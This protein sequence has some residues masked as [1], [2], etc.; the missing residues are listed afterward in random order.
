MSLR[1]VPVFFIMGLLLNECIN[2]AKLP[3]LQK[4]VLESTK[5]VSITYTRLHTD[6]DSLQDFYNYAISFQKRDS[7]ITINYKSQSP[8]LNQNNQLIVLVTEKHCLF[9]IGNSYSLT[10]TKKC[11]NDVKDTFYNAH[12]SSADKDDCSVFALKESK[13][14]TGIP[15]FHSS[16]FD[17]KS[18][19]YEI[20]E[21]KNCE[22]KYSRFK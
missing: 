17:F 10:L 22:A 5:I 20:T 18:S 6:K 11:I 13:S 12:T 16:L 1:I 2:S 9:E 4:I 7:V 3:S 15:A 14:T 19:L 21:F 8:L